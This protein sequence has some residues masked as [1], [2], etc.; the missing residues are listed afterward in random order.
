LAESEK[1]RKKLEVELERQELYYK[2]IF[3]IF[4][5]MYTSCCA[6]TATIL[7]C[8][9]KFLEELG[10]RREEV[11]GHMIFDFYHP[12]S[13]DEARNA[14]VAFITKGSVK[15]VPL[16][17][18]HKN[19]ASLNVRLNL[20]AVRDQN[21][22]IIRSLSVWTDFSEMATIEKKLKLL[23]E[24]F[25]H[26]V[27]AV[28]LGTWE[29]DLKSDLVVS[30]RHL[31]ELFDVM[32]E[33]T[34]TSKAYFDRVLPEDVMKLKLNISRAIQGK[35]EVHEIYRVVGPEGNVRTLLG[36]GKVFYDGKGQPLKIVGFTVDISK[37]YKN[38]LAT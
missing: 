5:H 19:G 16:K 29:W 34:I 17:M 25:Q 36:H 28:H 14:F 38:L 32:D 9:K 26:M 13:L 33:N 21:G 3:E 6:E 18:L 1:S 31:K 35:G 12:D 27:D 22:R 4:P 24:Q 37:H 8:N 15:D 2:T 20:R 10:Y 23:L 30:N 11:I 7:Y